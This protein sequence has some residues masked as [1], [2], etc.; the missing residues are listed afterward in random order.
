MVESTVEYESRVEYSM[1]DGATKRRVA[2]IEGRE[3]D[4]E[5][6]LDLKANRQGHSQRRSVDDREYWIADKYGRMMSN[7]PDQLSFW[8]NVEE[9]W[10]VEW[11][12]EGGEVFLSE[13]SA[14]A[15]K[16]PD[17]DDNNYCAMMQYV[18]LQSKVDPPKLTLY[19][20]ASTALVIVFVAPLVFLFFFTFCAEPAQ[21]VGDTR[22][23]TG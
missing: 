17:D 15:A 12:E 22:V 11:E 18:F 14:L 20:F 13:S 8:D 9:R 1:V 2:S 4:R 3:G 16:K 5:G 10:P 23:R 19:P 6:V 7:R 21:M